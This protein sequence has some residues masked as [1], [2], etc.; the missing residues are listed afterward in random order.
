MRASDTY[1]WAL[2]VTVGASMVIAGIRC[3]T[4]FIG[5]RLALKGAS[6]ADHL[7]IF[8]EFACAVSA[9]TNAGEV[10]SK[11]PAAGVGKVVAVPA[12]ENGGRRGRSR[13]RQRPKSPA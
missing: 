9:R 13:R 11:Q 2:A 5:L 1:M 7:G 8:R 6:E 3:L 12:P 10:G 4:L